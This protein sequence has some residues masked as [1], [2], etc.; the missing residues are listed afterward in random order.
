MRKTTVVPIAFEAR[1]REVTTRFC[2]VV[3]PVL[4]ESRLPSFRGVLRF[5]RLVPAVNVARSSRAFAELAHNRQRA[6]LTPFF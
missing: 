4:P 5:C 3:G 6:E 2:V 1:F